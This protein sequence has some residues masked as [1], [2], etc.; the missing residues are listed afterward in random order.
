MVLKKK[1][2]IKKKKVE[3]KYVSLCPVCGS[4]DFGFYKADKPMD[5]A[6]GEIYKCNRC[7]NIFSFPIELPEKEAKKLK[8][9][10]LTKEIL[11]DTPAEA[12]TSLGQF[13]IR[14]YWKILAIVTLLLAISSFYLSTVPM[15]CNMIEGEV[16]CLMNQNSR[17]FFIYGIA[18]LFSSIYLFIESMFLLKYNDSFPRALRT[19]LFLGLIIVIAST[20]SSVLF[21]VP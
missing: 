7:K 15:F 21:F 3:E 13:Q 16:F 6:G 14:V 4:K 19:I 2:N 20:G 1:K 5:V 10:A 8:P 11:R 18:L 12:L 17:E 9:I